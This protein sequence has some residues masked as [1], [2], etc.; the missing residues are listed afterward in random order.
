MLLA[1]KLCQIYKELFLKRLYCRFENGVSEFEHLG[2]RG[3]T[4]FL[5]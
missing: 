5:E 1:H 3:W 4:N 2:V